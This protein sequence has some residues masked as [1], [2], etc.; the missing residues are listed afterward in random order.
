MLVEEGNDGAG[1][2]VESM[3]SSMGRGSQILAGKWTKRIPRLRESK[4]GPKWNLG[5]RGMLDA[6]GMTKST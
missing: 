5:P 6:E 1:G 3:E 4:C 2:G